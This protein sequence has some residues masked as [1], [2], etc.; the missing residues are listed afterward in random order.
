MVY[1][2]WRGWPFR[3]VASVA[4]AYFWDCVDGQFARRYDD[5]SDFGDWYDHV[6]DVATGIT[7]W[8]ILWTRYTLR[9]VHFVLAVVLAVAINV[10]TACAQRNSVRHDEETLDIVK[11][12]CVGQGVATR[13][14]SGVD[15]AHIVW[16]RY[17]GHDQGPRVPAPVDCVGHR[18]GSGHPVGGA[19]SDTVTVGPR[20]SA[21]VTTTTSR[22]PATRGHS[23]AAFW[24]SRSKSPRQASFYGGVGNAQITAFSAA[25]IASHEVGC[26]VPVGNAGLVLPRA[27]LCQAH[28]PG[29]SARQSQ[30]TGNGQVVVHVQLQSRRLFLGRSPPSIPFQRAG[31]GYR[32]PAPPF[33]HPFLK[34]TPV[35]EGGPTQ[36]GGGPRCG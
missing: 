11:P 33:P 28:G 19:R 8:F 4:A 36:A 12:L 1:C 13:W 17:L 9:P 24:G 5:V 7:V 2:A 32:V 22:G 3:F 18:G 6:T 14:R 29:V 16:T 20:K 34:K 23:A 26:L 10:A 21:S 31:D 15:K 35:P 30:H 27:L 25:L